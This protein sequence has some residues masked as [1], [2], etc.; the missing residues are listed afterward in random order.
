MEIYTD[1]MVVN[2]KSPYKTSNKTT[3]WQNPLLGI[4]C[5]ENKIEKKKKECTPMFTAALSISISISISIYLSIY[6]Y[7]YIYKYIYKITGT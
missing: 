6:I 3:I 5:E 7:I 2:I 1:T 4:Y